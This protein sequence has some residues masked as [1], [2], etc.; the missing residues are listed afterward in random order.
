[1]HLFV[2][3][4]LFLC[5]LCMTPAEIT[6]TYCQT[7]NHLGAISESDK[8]GSDPHAVKGITV[9]ITTAVHC[10]QV[11]TSSINYSTDT[12]LNWHEANG[13]C[14]SCS[15]VPTLSPTSRYI[16]WLYSLYAAKI[17]LEFD[18]VLFYWF[19]LQCVRQQKTCYWVK[20]LLLIF[21][22]IYLF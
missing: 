16:L 8:T 17:P 9:A 22:T 11:F 1:M 7:L 15:E 10:F 12:G 19:C 13:S 3:H 18:F 2:I 5:W 20:Q 4:Q 14:Y 6:S 21:I